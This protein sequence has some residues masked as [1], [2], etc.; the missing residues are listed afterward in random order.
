[1]S[2]RNPSTRVQLGEILLR[3]GVVTDHGLVTALR[4]QEGLA[5]P[6]KPR[7]G[8]VMVQLGLASEEAI[9]R[10]VAEQLHLSYLELGVVVADAEMA[11]LIPH[12][13]AKNHQVLPVRLTDGRLLVAMADPTDLVALDDIRLTSGFQDI[14]VAVATSSGITDAI[15]RLYSVDV[16]AIDFLD[17]LGVA[18]QVEVLAEQADTDEVP[19][20]NAADMGP[21]TK[22]VNAMLADAVRGRATDIHIEPHPTEVK[23]RYRVDGLLRDVMSLPKHIQSLLVSRVKILSGLDI[24]ERRRPQDGRTKIIV[25]RRELD[26]RVATIPTLTGEKLVIRLLPKSNE[27]VGIS[28]LGMSD[29]QIEILTEHLSL[30]QG[31][32]IFTGPT[33]AG[34]TSTIYASLQHMKT[35]EKNILTL[36]DPIEYQVPGINQVQTNEKVGIT[37]A[38]GL[39]S[40]L[41]Q[42][43]DVIMVGEVRDSEAARMVVQSSLTGHLVITSLH[44]NDAASALT[45]LVDLGIEPFLISSA[46][47][48]VVAQRLVRK[49]CTE[50]SEH[51]EASPEM[52]SSM[53]LRGADIGQDA[54]RGAGC[55]ACGYTGY[56]G[57]TGIFEIMPISHPIRN[58]INAGASDTDIV[59]AARAASITSLRENG[60][61]KVNDSTTTLEEVLRVTHVD[62]EDA[63]RCHSCHH[64]VDAAFVMCPY[65]HADLGVPSCASCGKARAPEWTVCPY[66][67]A[68]VAEHQPPPLVSKPRLLVV[69]DDPSL[70]LLA[71]ALFS[72]EFD[73]ITAETGDECLRRAT[74]E[75]PDLILLDLNLPDV[76]GTEVAERLRNTVATSLIPLIMITGS[77]DEGQEVASLRAGVDDYVA[78]PFDEDALRARMAAVLRRVSPV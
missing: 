70:R 14:E 19:D 40:I 76:R 52:L 35:P 42:D 11:R 53:G 77:A 39:R 78:K 2:T 29:E 30:P 12:A 32:I 1:V 51:A 18:S 56:R 71:E 4:W 13:V 60:I 20:V 3:A 61:K 25:E 41:R 10:A 75:R 48:M 50:C 69:D 26:A 74:L 63:L 54:M 65:C 67:R 59:Q 5:G 72:T 58:L 22:L 15:G 55:E 44:T 36:E 66:C 62:R 57:R 27:A 34:K 24:S 31:L 38:R 28:E 68:D 37:F 33:G 6:R 9:A 45:R 73:V 8:A 49:I 21:I 47:T 46:L 43:P 17:R 7:L 23:V 64:E 16:P